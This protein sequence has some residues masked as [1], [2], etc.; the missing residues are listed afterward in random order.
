VTNSQDCNDTCPS[1]HPGGIEIVRDGLDQ[2]CNGYDLTI[3]VTKSVWT[4]S[5]KSLNVVA[6]SLLNAGANLAL[7]SPVSKALTWSA[8]A[9][10][11]STTVSNVATNPGSVTVAGPEGSVVAPVTAQ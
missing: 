1:C 10:T 8:T 4:R 2:D 6:T 9:K 3:V 11:W 5:K 7:Q